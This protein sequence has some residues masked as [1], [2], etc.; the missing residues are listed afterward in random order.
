M[1]YDDNSVDQ[2]KKKGVF[3]DVFDPKVLQLS[4]SEKHKLQKDLSRHHSENDALTIDD[5][6]INDQHE[7]HK[8]GDKKELEISVVLNPFEKIFMFLLSFFGIQTPNEYKIHKA[9]KVVEK[10]IAH[11]KPPIYYPSNRRISKFFAFKI[12]NLFIRLTPVKKLFDETFANDKAWSNTQYHKKTGIEFLFEKMMQ[13]NTTT[14]DENFSETR[15]TRT[16]Y[17]L[18]NDK[19]AFDTVDKAIHSYLSSLSSDS[20]EQINRWYTNLVYFKKLADYDFMQLFRRFDSQFSLSLAPSFIDVST[21]GFTSF[22]QDLEEAVMQIDL[23]MDNEHLFKLLDETA[24]YLFLVNQKEEQDASVPTNVTDVS[25][26][27]EINQFLKALKE[28]SYGSDLT[29]LLRLIKKDPSYVPVFIH[30]RF[31]FYKMYME[32]FDQRIKYTT[33]LVMKNKK[34]KKIEDAI[35]KIFDNVQWVGIY[36]PDYSKKLEQMDIAGFAY[37]YHIGIINT[38]LTN[39][40]G[41]IIKGVLNLVLLNGIF[42]D[43]FIQKNLSEIFYEMDK[44][45]ETFNDYI[46]DLGPEGTSG[47]KILSILSRPEY[48]PAENKKILER[49]ILLVNNKAKDLFDRFSFFYTNISDIITKIYHDMDLKPPRNIKNIRSIGGIK[50]VKFLNSVERSFDI[51]NS[52]KESISVLR[53]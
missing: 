5:K 39:Y 26:A 46:Y 28:L 18:N 32:T 14:L 24:Q 29:L 36:N 48:Q 19:L 41:D 4:E 53:E 51:V 2:A 11:I 20:V 6:K 27:E 7:T 40:Y 1:P 31:D 8:K 25:F 52:L 12:H 15:I 50:N 37:C 9:L 34:M 42:A 33:Q 45:Q 21:D 43:K 3:N 30:T 23:S 22:F 16:I 38:F 44:Y 35:H 49:N 10:D 13:L 17:E 47:K